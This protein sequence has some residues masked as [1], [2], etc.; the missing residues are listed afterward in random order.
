MYFKIYLIST[1]I[2]LIILIIYTRY[3]YY[4]D[5]YNIDLTDKQDG[6]LSADFRNF[7]KECNIKDLVKGFHNW[8]RVFVSLIISVIVI[9]Y[10]LNILIFMVWLLYKLAMKIDKKLK[11]QAKFVGFKPRK[12]NRKYGKKNSKG[13]SGKSKVRG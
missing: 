1:T 9:I 2:S 8:D 10:F 11:D 3:L 7:I 5:K 13:E 12:K 4:L 6:R